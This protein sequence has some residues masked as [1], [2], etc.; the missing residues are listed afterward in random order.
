[1]DDEDSTICDYC[2][3]DISADEVDDAMPDDTGYCILCGR[4]LGTGNNEDDED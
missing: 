4:Y 2:A 1:M 3:A